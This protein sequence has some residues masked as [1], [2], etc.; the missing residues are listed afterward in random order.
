M[1]AIRLQS[2]LLRRMK[3][4]APSFLSMCHTA[5]GAKGMFLILSFEYKLFFQSKG[6]MICQKNGVAFF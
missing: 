6:V 3:S 5:P 2:S 4:T 1:I